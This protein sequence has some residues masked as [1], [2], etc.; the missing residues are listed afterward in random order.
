MCGFALYDLPNVDV[1]GYDVVSNRPKT[2]A[3]RAP[4]APIT[5]FAVE[6]LLDDLARKLQMDP[7]TLRE[8]N[9]ARNG[10]KTHCGPSHQ[11]I[12]FEAVLASMKNHPHWQSPLQPGHGRGMACGF[13]FNVGGESTAQVHINEDGSVT[14]ATGSPDIS[15]GSRASIG[16]MVA[17]ARR[18]GVTRSHGGRRHGVH[19]Y[20]VTGGSRVTFA[21]A[22]LRRAAERVVEELK[23]RAAMIWEIDRGGRMGQEGVCGGQRG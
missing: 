8:K 9:A 4:G 7:L 23:K 21:A 6:S 5:S 3:Y 17:G 1:I 2:A 19:H 20:P 12:G 11:N 10:T 15:G 13:W 22:W 14:A 18:S 16:M